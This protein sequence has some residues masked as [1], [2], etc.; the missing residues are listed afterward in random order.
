LIAKVCQHE[1]KERI[2]VFTHPLSLS[3]FLITWDI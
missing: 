2:T 3:L 1:E